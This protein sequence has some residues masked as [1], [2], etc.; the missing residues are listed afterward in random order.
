MPPAGPWR[1]LRETLPE[2]FTPASLKT[3]K[4]AKE[5]AGTETG[6]PGGRSILLRRPQGLGVRSGQ[7]RD[8]TMTAWAA[9]RR[10]MGTRKGE[11]LT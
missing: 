2:D 8:A 1:S 11:Q 4:I 9:A 10:A 3:A 6:A 7:R 5:E